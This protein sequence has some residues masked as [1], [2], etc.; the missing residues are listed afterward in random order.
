MKHEVDRKAIKI[1]LAALDLEV[2]ELATAMG[3]DGGYVTNVINGFTEASPSFRRAFGETI[4][5]FVFGR[6]EP[7]STESYPPGPLVE[8][9]LRAAAQAP[10]KR[11][12]Y[13]ELGTSAQAL[14]NRKSLDGILVDRICCA[15]GVHPSSV[16]GI[17]DEVA[18]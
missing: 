14:K 7:S 12:F 16:Y 4:A 6:F 1:L 10:S 8:L 3:Y 18:S 2:H 17:D 13:R 5:T 9:V 11:E 15:L